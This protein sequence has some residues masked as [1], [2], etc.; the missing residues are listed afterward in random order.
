MQLLHTAEPSLNWTDEAKTTLL[1]FTR[2]TKPD[3]RTNWHH[4][5]LAEKLDRV[6]TG[7]CRRL[8][9]FL[10]PQHGKSELVSRRFPAFLLGRNPELRLIGCSHT[11]D[12]AISMNRDVQRIITSKPYGSVFDDIRLNERWVRSSSRLEARRTMDL[13]EIPGYGGSLRSAGVGNSIAGNAADG[14]IIDDPF[15]KREDADP[16]RQV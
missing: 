4:Q 13:F 5:R 16:M 14:A 6:A 9:V 7:Q 10:P 1:A 15:G 3:Y 11:S 12:L 8:M 2:F